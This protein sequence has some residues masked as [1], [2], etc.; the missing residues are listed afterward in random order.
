[1]GVGIGQPIVRKLVVLEEMVVDVKIG[2][3]GD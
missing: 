3:R 1:M 2:V